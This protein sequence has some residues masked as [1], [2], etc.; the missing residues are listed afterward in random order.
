MKSMVLVVAAAG[1]VVVTGDVLRICQN[2]EKADEIV[3]HH[4]HNPT[5]AN[6]D[7][8]FTDMKAYIAALPPLLEALK[9]DKDRTIEVCKDLLQLG[10]SRFMNIQYDYDHLVKGFNWTDDDMNTYRDLRDDTLTEWVKMEPF[11]F[12]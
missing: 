10:T 4:V 8:V 7:R 1:L 5:I 11:I 3:C 9:A 12:E 6:R 2:V